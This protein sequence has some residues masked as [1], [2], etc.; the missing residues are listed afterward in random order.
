MEFSDAR[1]RALVDAATMF[2]IAM[3]SIGSSMRTCTLKA[4]LGLMPSCF[5]TDRLV[6]EV[7]A[8]K[9][10]HGYSLFGRR[11]L[12]RTRDLKEASMGGQPDVC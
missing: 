8:H 7:L 11:Y 9:V 1:S 10:L 12:F 6:I 4:K 5:G 3:F 2:E